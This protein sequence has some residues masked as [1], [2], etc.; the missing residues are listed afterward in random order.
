MPVAEQ[1]LLK[2]GDFKAFRRAL[3]SWTP[4]A[5]ETAFEREM[6][7]QAD[8]YYA[9]WVKMV[10]SRKLLTSDAFNLF[11]QQQFVVAIRDIYAAPDLSEDGL[12]EC[13]EK[14]E[15]TFA[16]S[17]LAEFLVEEGLFDENGIF[18]SIKYGEDRQAYNTQ[19]RAAAAI[20]GVDADPYIAMFERSLRVQALLAMQDWIAE[21]FK[22]HICA[23]NGL[24]E[25]GLEKIL[26]RQ[27][28]PEE[29]FS[30]S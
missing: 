15:K 17:P 25:K 10:S 27:H 3:E 2:D 5:D 21:V 18:D 24:G 9:A 4:D 22:S 23:E 28:R 26:N 11:E 1:G 7:Q 20:Q 29:P 12:A 14:E 30:R 13:M 8:D 6:Y 16:S 19:F